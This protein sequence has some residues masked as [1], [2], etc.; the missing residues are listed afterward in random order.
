VPGLPPFDP[1]ALPAPPPAPHMQGD[2][3]RQA[4]DRDPLIRS[5][6][7]FARDKVKDALKDADEKLADTAI[8]ALPLDPTTKAA[9]KAVVDALLKLAKGQRFQMPTAPTYQLPPSS[10]GPLPSAPGLSFT[11]RF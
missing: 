3:L 7:G 11:Y 8:G 1:F 9:V 2:W 5:L 10:L 6:P 4:L